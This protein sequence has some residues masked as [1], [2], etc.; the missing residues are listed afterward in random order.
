MIVHLPTWL[1]LLTLQPPSLPTSATN[2]A[3]SAPPIALK[4]SQSQKPVGSN[5]KAEER[6]DMLCM[7]TD[8]ILSVNPTMM[9]RKHVK[10][11]AGRI[12]VLHDHNVCAEVSYSR[13][14]ATI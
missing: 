10:P 1:Y 14:N 13:Y 5:L 7:F 4:T 11:I 8:M 9:E 12:R 2:A 3:Y 6:M